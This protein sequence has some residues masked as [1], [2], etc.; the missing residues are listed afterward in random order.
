MQ[1]TTMPFEVEF[2]PFEDVCFLS[3]LQLGCSADVLN[4]Y[5]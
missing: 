2:E 3:P 5:T 1:F 4:I